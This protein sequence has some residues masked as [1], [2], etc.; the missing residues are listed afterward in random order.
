MFVCVAGIYKCAC[1]QGGETGR[2]QE[3][4]NGSIYH[5]LADVRFGAAGRPI[6]Q[7]ADKICLL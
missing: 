2:V 7:A 4:V 5:R 6:G 3:E 1:F